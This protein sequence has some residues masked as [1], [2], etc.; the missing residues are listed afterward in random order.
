MKLARNLGAV[1]LILAAVWLGIFFFAGVGSTLGLATGAALAAIFVA[2]PGVARN[3]FLAVFSTI[4]AVSLCEFALR[5][6][7]V[8]EDIASKWGRGRVQ[9]FS[10]PPFEP[11]ADFGFDAIA[12]VV[13]KVT[14]R[15]NGKLVYEVTYSFDEH[16]ARVAPGVA[17]A[18]RTIVVA[19]DSFN[20]GEGLNDNQTLAY[21][22]QDL[23][24]HQF[25]ALNIARPGYGL[26]QVLRQ[27]ELDV[28]ARDG[29]TS[30]GWVIVSIV[31]NH[32]ERVNGRYSWMRG[33]PRYLV[34]RHGAVHLSGAFGDEGGPTLQD[35]LRQNSR[36]IAT[37]DK[38][39]QKMM[40]A[41]DERRFVGVLHAIH[42]NVEHKYHAKCLVLYHSG[43]AFLNDL[44]GRRATMHRLLEQAGVSYVDV[45]E[46]IPDIDAS[47]FIDD[48]GHPSEKMN[49]AL[50]GMIL[51]RIGEAQ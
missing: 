21:H 24:H 22:L 27:L 13:T 28:P 25:W 29:A 12:N 5:L 39:W 26:H 43:A 14:S 16:G 48:D 8:E 7:A 51:R 20:F 36:L 15:H 46:N 2:M 47:Y 30:F 38:L 10:V 1:V 9:Q 23:S 31:D 35:K 41:D 33:T 4:F 37:L 17:K 19:G 34:D 49:I 44:V 45:N 6:P 50:A 40:L 18:D 3:V 32:I 42:E 11:N